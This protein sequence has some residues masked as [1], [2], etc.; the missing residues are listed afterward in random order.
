[1]SLIKSLLV[2]TDPFKE[3]IPANNRNILNIAEFCSPKWV[4]FFHTGQFSDTGCMP[5]NLI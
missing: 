2:I 3:S 1:V 5:Y 4:E